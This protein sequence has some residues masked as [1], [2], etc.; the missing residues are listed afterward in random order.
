[1]STPTMRFDYPNH[2]PGPNLSVRRGTQWDGV[3]EAIIEGL[4]E[5]RPLRT[6]VMRFCDLT[7]EDL[8]MEHDPSARTCT[9]LLVN[10]ENMY[11]DFDE[12][13]LVTLVYYEGAGG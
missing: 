2:N 11:L 3:K 4:D 1:M 5:R 6:I 13:E 9:D 8:A 12:R 7:D 10:L